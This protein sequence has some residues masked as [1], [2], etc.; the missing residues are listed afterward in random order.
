MF[1]T[2]YLVCF[3]YHV[4]TDTP[5][6]R[7]LEDSQKSPSDNEFLPLRLTWSQPHRTMASADPPKSKAVSSDPMNSLRADLAHRQAGIR[8]GPKA[9]KGLNLVRPHALQTQPFSHVITLPRKVVLCSS[10]IKASRGAWKQ[11][12]PLYARPNA[13]LN[14]SRSIWSAR[15]N[16]TITLDVVTLVV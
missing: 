3:R 9:K 15:R 10:Q 1:F 4:T 11:M 13:K 16:N 5:T 8:E 14:L 6:P 12:L 7:A 2:L